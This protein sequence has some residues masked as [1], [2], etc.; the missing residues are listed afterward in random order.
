MSTDSQSI[1]AVLQSANPNTL[2]DMLRLQR[3]DRMFQPISATCTITSGTSIDLTTLRVV[4]SGAGAVVSSNSPIELG[5]LLPPIRY[6]RSLRVVTGT[7]T[8]A[9]AITDAAGT[10]STTLATLSE[11][12]KTLTFEAAITVFLLVFYGASDTAP[13]ADANTPS[14]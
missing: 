3:V 10:P 7:A 9:R 8:G 5:E 13:T 14:P 1:L 11:D 4:A 2:P 12:G 6:L